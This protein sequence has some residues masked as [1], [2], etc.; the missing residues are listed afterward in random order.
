M[1]GEA[2]R[3]TYELTCDT[4]EDAARRAREIAFEQTVELPESCVTPEVCARVVGQV[5]SVEPAGPS[6]WH[7]AIRY[8][9][10]V[11]GP[12][13]PQLL[14]LLFGNI[15]LQQ[16]I[17]ITRV[18]WPD[19]WLAAMPGPRRGMQGLRELCA[20]EKRR[21]L[22]CAALK[23]VGLTAQELAA[24]CSAFAQGGVDIIKDDHGL[25]DQ[26]DAPFAE[27]LRRCAEAV[28]QVNARTGGSTRYFPN[29]NGRADELESRLEA[30]REAGCRGILISPLLAG[31]DVV[32][33]IAEST[34]LAILAHPALSGAYFQPGHGIRPEILLGQ[35]FRI[36]GSDGVI[37]PNAGGRFPFG[38]ETCEAINARLREPLGRLRPAAPLPGGGI[39]ARR[40]PYWIERYGPDTIF[41]VGGSLYAQPDLAEAGRALLEAIRSSV[42]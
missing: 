28:A 16:G 38:E 26:V 6:R 11:V 32:R 21:P 15:S 41:L 20:V 24:T 37:Y 19:G 5:E 30:V 7:A 27:R 2:F 42:A 17:V 25:A 1:T 12:E 40:V 31:P 4:S 9:E 22:L 39:D 18:D 34:E 29:V 10:R 3:I 33:W 23:P 13:L 36:L 8:S 14:N 35:V